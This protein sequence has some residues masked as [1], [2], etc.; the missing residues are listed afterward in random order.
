MNSRGYFI[1]LE[2]GEGAGKTT[3]MNGLIEWIKSQNIPLLVTREPGGTPVS[4][5][6]RDLVLHGDYITPEAELLMVFAAR[7]QHVETVIRPAL[8]KGTWVLSDRFVDA[9]FAYQGAG[10]KLPIDWIEDLQHRVVGETMPDRTILLDISVELGQTRIGARGELDRM[11]KS[12]L[13]FMQRVRKQY[14]SRAKDQPQRFTLIDASQS[15]E[16]VL[17][18]AIQSINPEFRKSLSSTNK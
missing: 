12:G 1:S 10:R 8:A 3:L 17:D 7:A 2:G 15:A 18:L 6:L 5:K 14:L 11:E 4:E 13:D 9:S 16:Q